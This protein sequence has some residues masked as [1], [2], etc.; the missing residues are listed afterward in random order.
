M[1]GELMKKTASR[2]IFS[3]M[4]TEYQGLIALFPLRPIHDRV[5]LANA[6]EIADAMAGHDLTPDQEDYFDV[7]TTLMNEYE[8]AHGAPPLRQH[9]PIGNL[10]FL[11]DQHGL[12]ASDVGRI[13]GQRELGSKILRGDRELSKAHIRTL[14]D[15]FHVNAGV[16]V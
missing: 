14:A 3:A 10:E 16:F 2:L 13:L 1:E 4:P 15:Y 8:R 11:M 9:D 6:T 12:T 7:L 5:D